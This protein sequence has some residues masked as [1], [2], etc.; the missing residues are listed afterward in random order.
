MA[1][2][3]G[4]PMT[5]RDDLASLAGD[6]VEAEGFPGTLARHVLGVLAAHPDLLVGWL[7]ETGV[8]EQVGWEQ[9]STA[10]GS[11]FKSLSSTSLDGPRIRQVPVFRV[12]DRTDTT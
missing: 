9:S 8:L 4:L 3:E 1:R 12:T 6:S 2:R 10:L 7:Q 5:A 11:V